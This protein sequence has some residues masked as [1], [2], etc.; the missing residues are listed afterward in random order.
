MP[1][2]RAIRAT[3]PAVPKDRCAIVLR[4]SVAPTPPILPIPPMIPHAAVSPRLV[5]EARLRLVR[6]HYESGVGHLGGN[7]SSIDALLV[8]L[9]EFIGEDDSLILSKGHSAGALY[10]ALWSLGRLSDD[11]LRS[12]HR[13]DTLLAGHPPAAGIADIPFATGSLGHGLSLAAGSA[14]GRRM[15]GSGRV[16]CLTS[17][18]EWQEGSTWEALT[19]AAHHRLSNLTVLV[20]HNGL[21]GF[22][23]TAEVASMS[24]LWNKLQGFDVLVDVIDGHDLDAI[25]STLMRAGDRPRIVCLQTVKGKGVSFLEHRMDSHYLPLSEEKFRIATSELDGA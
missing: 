14:L 24:P 8:A 3:A 12:F 17:D 6:M 4:V 23:T 19:F 13:D 22:G 20:D 9:H 1:D 10:V 18:G 2:A 11:D 21:Q 25:R 5:R 15:K 7:L 16:I